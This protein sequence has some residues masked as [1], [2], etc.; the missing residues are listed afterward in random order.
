[1]SSVE[2]RQDLGVVVLAEAV[3]VGLDGLLVLRHRSFPYQRA[4]IHIRAGLMARIAWRRGRYPRTDGRAHA[5]RA[6]DLER[7][8]ERADTVGEPAQSR[9]PRGVN[10]A[11]AVVRTSTIVCPS[12]LR[13]PHL[14]PIRVG[15]LEAFVSASATTSTWCLHRQREFPAAV[16]VELDRH[17]RAAGHRRKRGLEAAIGEDAGWIPRA[18][19]RSSSS[20]ASSSGTRPR[21]RGSPRSWT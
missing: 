15:V 4:R 6:L 20:A 7:A 19:S 5:D 18:S 2:A 9:A 17:R 3:E 8:A 16:E 13:D 21:A 11:A 10:A 1:M 14:D 12:P